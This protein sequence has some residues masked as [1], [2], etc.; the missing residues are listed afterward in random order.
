ML[1]RK[2]NLGLEV[3]QLVSVAYI[4]REIVQ[5]V[6]ELDRQFSKRMSDLL[7]KSINYTTKDN[8]YCLDMVKALNGLFSVLK[9]PGD[10]RTNQTDMAFRVFKKQIK[11]SGDMIYISMA[12]DLIS[13]VAVLILCY[14]YIRL[15]NQKENEYYTDYRHNNL[16]LRIYKPEFE[17]QAIG[18]VPI[19]KILDRG[20]FSQFY[21]WALIEL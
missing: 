8:H 11:F 3:E 1:N 6:L 2:L 21:L 18:K 20:T 12:L 9:V 19:D 16:V 4:V 14:K 5:F 7:G 17:Y 10:L 13:F 15:K